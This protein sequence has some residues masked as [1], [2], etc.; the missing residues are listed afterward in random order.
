MIKF[1]STHG[2]NTMKLLKELLARINF[3][4]NSKDAQKKQS[5]VS[6]GNGPKAHTRPATEAGYNSL[7][8]YWTNVWIDGMHLSE[9]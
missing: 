2:K 8:V 5:K 4:I 6:K 9:L 7:Y 3:N 1:S